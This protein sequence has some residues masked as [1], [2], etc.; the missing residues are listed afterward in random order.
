MSDKKSK[1]PGLLIT[2]AVL[3]IAAGAVFFLTQ[4][5]NAE[6][7]KSNIKDNEEQIFAVNTT[8]AVEGQI[9]DYLY[10]NGDII[11]KEFVDVYPDTAGKITDILV[12]LG[13]YVRKGE[14][15]A[16]VDPSRPGMNFAKSPVYSPISGTITSFPGAVGST[17]SQQSPM[18]RIGN[19]RDLQVRTFISERK[20]SHITLGM[21][22]ELS[23][24]AYPGETFKARITELSP[25]VDPSSRSMEIKLDLTNRDK[26]IKSGMFTKIK[27]T[28]SVKNKIVK[29]PSDCISERFGEKF[30]FIIKD[31]GTA[32]KRAIVEGISIN[33]VSEILSGLSVN[34]KV[35]IQGQ[36]LLDNGVKVK[37]IKEVAPLS[38]NIKE[39]V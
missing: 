33:D 25:V 23:F 29:I 2:L 4:K 7:E 24:E 15:M 11:A 3:I 1:I 18:A 31:D 30:V 17:I 20:I 9:V 13:T 6:K 27:I 28:T 22:G 34:E 10:V 12:T 16:Y 14:I 32:E 39:E 37:I 38:Q 36:S 26:R 35:V 19:L 8:L 5:S 21:P